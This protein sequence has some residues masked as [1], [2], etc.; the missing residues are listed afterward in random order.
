MN[1][2][3]SF[4]PRLP[5]CLAA[6]L[7]TLTTCL[8]TFWGISELYYE[9]WGLPFPQPLA[10]LVPAAL[11]LALS[12]LTLRQPRTGGWVLLLGG[13]AFTLLWWGLAWRRLG[14][15]KPAALLGMIPVSA[16]L[17]VTGGLFLLEARYRART[18]ATGVGGRTSLLLA[19]GLPLLVVLTVTVSELPPLLHRHDDGMRGPRRITAP[20]VDLLWAPQGP[21]W[22][23]KQPWGGY[24]SWNALA[25]YGKPPL[26]LE[27]KNEWNAQFRDMQTTGLCAYLSADGLTLLETPQF[28]WRMPTVEELLRSL[29]RDGHSANCRWNGNLGPA[30]C[31]ILP[32]KETPLWDPAAP[33]VYYWAAE[34][35]DSEQAYFVNY[36]GV[37]NIQPKDFGNPR[38]GYRCVRE[39]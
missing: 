12:L 28:V 14:A 18:G 22:N 7:M 10:Y 25:L 32:D 4:T 39:P 37:V 24:P 27:P 13:A 38:H 8:W 26:G 30:P 23:W 35:F 36:R 31:A 33:P 6:A 9:G 17:C 34:E 21:G 2:M 19:G 20:G 11:C 5:G 1:L 3:K 16:L 15:P 29:T